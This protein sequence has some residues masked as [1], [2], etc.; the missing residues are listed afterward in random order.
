MDLK[1]LLPLLLAGNKNGENIAP[2][3]NA[4][5]AGSKSDK[6]D[7]SAENDSAVDRVLGKNNDPMLA[8]VLKNVMSGNGKRN[9]S[10]GVE[11]I[12]GI[13]NDEILGKIV[14]YLDTRG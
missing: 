9:G 6:S 3:I 2:L 8:N 5:S 11:Q 10:Y 13:A 7:K 4:M 12:S 1:A 14:K